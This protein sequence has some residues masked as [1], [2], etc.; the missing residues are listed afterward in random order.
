M[1]GRERRGGKECEKGGKKMGER[2][3]DA[4]TCI[5]Q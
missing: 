4:Q 2:E 1:E 3:I 5:L